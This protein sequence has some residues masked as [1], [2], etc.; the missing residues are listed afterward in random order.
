[1]VL[2]EGYLTAAILLK[3][4]SKAAKNL[5]LAFGLEGEEVKDIAVSNVVGWTPLSEGSWH[6]CCEIGP[7]SWFLIPTLSRVFIS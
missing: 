7:H 1:M 3:E 4:A 6:V 2:R 5:A